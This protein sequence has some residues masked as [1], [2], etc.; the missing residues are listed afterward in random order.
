MQFQ[1]GGTTEP[2]DVRDV[3]ED[4]IA[5]A[6]ACIAAAPSLP[7]YARVDGVIQ[8]GRFLLMELEVFEPLMFLREHPPAADRFA[9]AIHGRLTADRA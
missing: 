7:V 9:R 2:V 4:W 1:F 3:R 6:R 5:G 8:D